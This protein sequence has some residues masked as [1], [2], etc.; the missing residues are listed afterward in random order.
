MSC[1]LR[2]PRHVGAWRR[3][4][5]ILLMLTCALLTIGMAWATDLPTLSGGCSPTHSEALQPSLRVADAAITYCDGGDHW[6]GQIELRLPKGWARHYEVYVA[7]FTE[8]PGVSLHLEGTTT[9]TPPQAN[10]GHEW[11][12][13]TPPAEGWGDA[14]TRI[15]LDD[16]STAAF[17]WGGIGY[18][19]RRLFEAEPAAYGRFFARTLG[20]LLALLIPALWCHAK[21]RSN[22][23]LFF[24]PVA[25][26]L[27]TALCGLAFWMFPL[28]STA[29]RAAMLTLYVVMLLD[30]AR[31]MLSKNGHTRSRHAAGLRF[32]LA[33]YALLV[34]QAVAIGIN[35]L[36]VTQEF[37]GGSSIPGRMIASPPDHL[38]PY[39]T[40]SYFFHGYDGVEKS[41]EY[42]GDD[43][44]V[45][46]RGPIAP[47]GISALMHLLDAE[48]SDPP[49]LGKGAW[50]ANTESDGIDIARSYG[51]LT[52]SLIIFGALHLLVALGA[53]ETRVRLGLVWVAIA[54]VALIGTVFVWP[55]LLA[56]HFIL[57]AIACAWRGR[58][59]ISAIMAALAWMSHPVGALMMPALLLLILWRNLLVSKSSPRRALRHLVVSLASFALVMMPWI[60]FKASLPHHDSFLA[61]ALGDG[62]GLERFETVGTWTAARLRNIWFTLMPG[63]FFTSDLMRT[64]IEGDVSQ[65]AR[66][67][68]QSAKTLPGNL[69]VAGVLVAYVAI[70]RRSLGTQAGS[71]FTCAVAGGFLTMLV[72]WGYS[73]DGLGR[74]SLD[75]IAFILAVCIACSPGVSTHLLKWFVIP[76]AAIETRLVEWIGFMPAL[77]SGG[78]WKLDTVLALCVSTC[79]CL[80]LLAMALRTSCRITSGPGTPAFAEYSTR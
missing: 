66:W 53:S 49:S 16:S 13:M 17:G 28:A 46:S 23:Y 42:F 62:R 52:N 38:I 25:G 11:T 54:P 19:E 71:V 34:V 1:N 5:R 26:V 59:A 2:A 14:D 50:P 12:L 56:V 48:P 57:M 7:G 79:A 45:T 32:A 60:F 3:A 74:N 4:L 43:W 67:A 27:F 55:K 37:A 47:L 15:V 29:I 69:G 65:S 21:S 80:S 22:A 20:V 78:E 40:A 39:F 9:G 64:W 70:F 35:P 51:W 10:P 24:A 41:P 73:A 77:V 33:C 30:L 76:V 63:A 6:Q 18:G 68:I 36:P 8:T 61:Y 31:I 72:F 75:P 44:S 58:S